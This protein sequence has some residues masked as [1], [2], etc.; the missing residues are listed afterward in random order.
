MDGPTDGRTDEAAYRVA[1]SRLKN[2]MRSGIAIEFPIIRVLKQ[3]ASSNSLE[4]MIKKS[5]VSLSRNRE[6]FSYEKWI[7][8]YGQYL[9]QIS[10][11]FK[12]L[13]EV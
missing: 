10:T 4:V 3:L 12:K 11:N 1:C 5:S 8:F 13:H 7:N 2:H 9:G 6:N